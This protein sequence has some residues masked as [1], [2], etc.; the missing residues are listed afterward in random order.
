MLAHQCGPAFEGPTWIWIGYLWLFV[1][2]LYFFCR[3]LFD[4][5]IVQ[6][7][8]LAPNLQ[9]G[10]LVWLAATL[11]ICMLAVAYRQAERHIDLGLGNGHSHQPIASLDTP[12]Q[13]V[14]AVA[15]LW[16]AWPAWA[17]AAL[18]FAGHIV[19][20]VLLVLI[21]WRHFQDVA[22]G[23]AAATFYLL[24]PYTGFYVGQLH[25]V[26]PMALFLGAVL[27]YRYPTLAGCILGLATGA[28]YFPVF[29]LPL[30]LS[31]Y[32]GRGIGRFLVAYLIVLAAFLGNMYLTLSASDEWNKCVQNAMEY[33]AW[34]P[35]M[36][37]NTESFW[38]G[39]HWAYRIPVFLA[40][41]AFI[42]GTMFWPT[43][44]NLAHV[45]AL[46]TA[47]FISL[48][49]WFADQGGAYV[50]WYLPLLLLLFFRPNMQ[51][52]VPPNLDPEEDWLTRA[53]RWPLGLL[54]RIFQRS[55]PA[56]PASVPTGTDN[57]R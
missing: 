25:H 51:D 39:V 54:H 34:Q 21:G 26:L 16:D 55:E 53:L 38:T 11:L 32:R 31:F 14:F 44:K 18:A 2:S 20:I 33:A 47:I 23:M 28:T 17:V 15:V 24:L 46:T 37:P 4:L 10:G 52:R 7:P 48:Q 13:P 9:I 19:I 43:P 22:S 57:N 50:L 41:L 56:E 49:W 45:I 1:G 27:A 12:G 42:A 35:W 40:F 8:A 3:C 6:R 5:M 30:W 36:I 29:T